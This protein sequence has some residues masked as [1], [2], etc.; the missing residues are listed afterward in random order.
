MRKTVATALLGALALAACGDDR[1]TETIDKAEGEILTRSV[2]DDMLPYEQ[3][4]SQP[5]LADPDELEDGE[6]GARRSASG[7]GGGSATDTASGEAASGSPE[8]AA[9]PDAE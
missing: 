7:G 8:P 4:T 1:A 2:T 9:T 6:S 5:P 3:L